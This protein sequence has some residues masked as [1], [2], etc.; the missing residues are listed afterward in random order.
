MGATPTIDEKIAFLHARITFL[1][2]YTSEFTGTVLQAVGGLDAFSK[3]VSRIEPPKNLEVGGLD[4]WKFQQ[5]EIL[6]FLR[7]LNP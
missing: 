5:F 1:T 6:K 4:G 7:Q 3:A 2:K